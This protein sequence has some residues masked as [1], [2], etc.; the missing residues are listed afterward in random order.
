MF[1]YGS[2]ILIRELIKW[3][4]ECRHFTKDRLYL[5]YFLLDA[6]INYVVDAD[7]ARQTCKATRFVGRAH[8]DL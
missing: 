8:F 6:Q 3:K 7:R 2:I 4:K 1:T 5:I